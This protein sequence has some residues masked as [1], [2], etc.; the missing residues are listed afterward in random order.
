MTPVHFGKQSPAMTGHGSPIAQSTRCPDAPACIRTSIWACPALNHRPG[1]ARRLKNIGGSH[2]QKETKHVRYFGKLKELPLTAIEPEGWLR[3]YLENQRHG[4]TGHMEAAGYPFNTRGWATL[5]RIDGGTEAWWPFEQIAYWVD[6]AIRCGHL[7]ADRE[8]VAKAARQLDFTLTHPD[9]DGYLGPRHMKKD[10]RDNRWSHA[11]FFRALMA[12]YDAAGRSDILQALRRHYLSRTSPHCVNRDV[13]N[14]E[15]MLWL[16]ART[17]D[18]RILREAAKAYCRYQKRHPNEDTAVRAMASPKRITEHGVTFNEIAKLGA[19]VYLFTG[20]RKCLDATLHAYRKVDR[21]QML[22]D[23]IHSS[24]EHLRGKDP[25]D[26]HETCDIADYTWAVGYLLMATGNVAYADK[27]ERACFNAAPGAVKSDDFRALQYFS[28]PNQ[29]VAARNSNHNIYHH[30]K[31]WMSF[32]PNPGTECCPGEV[33]RILPNYVAR[34]WMQERD[35]GLVALLY[36]PGRVTAKAGKR[37]QSVTIVEDTRYPFSEQIDFVIKS[38]KPVEFPLTLRIP[39][40]CRKARVL[41]NG[42]PLNLACKR[43]SFVRIHHR[44]RPNERV[45]LVLPM[46]LKLSRWPRGGVSIERGPLVYAL[47]IREVWK[48][49]RS[50]PRQTDEFP[51]YNVYPGSPWNYALDVNAKTVDQ[52]VHVVHRPVVNNPWSADG[53]PIELRVPA[54]RVR[55]WVLEKRKRILFTDNGAHLDKAWPIQGDFVFT[56]QLP[57]PPALRKRL[58]K[59]REMVTLVPYGCTHLRLAVFPHCG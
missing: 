19:A 1:W 45:S 57:D 5:G 52:A 54:R 59:K 58:S 27:I 47:R 51:A 30:G 6:G 29:V 53:A 46:E 13:A 3:V 26:S 31:K 34:Q 7:L 56:P 35:G 18:R 20:N 24:S 8:L 43:G 21:D 16:Y 28:C 25:L 2:N 14:V 11:V 23:G 40:W 17:G 49:D 55:G 33:N 36:G 50:E 10:G 38:D 12:H 39:G 48:R 32:R 44:F 42:K 22:V 15:P 37:K 41:L 9:A 4:L